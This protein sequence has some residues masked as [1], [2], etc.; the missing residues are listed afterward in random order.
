[1]LQSGENQK[2]ILF[3]YLKLWNFENSENINLEAHN[4]EKMAVKEIE[5]YFNII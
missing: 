5:P 4:N 2:S 3:F 1:M